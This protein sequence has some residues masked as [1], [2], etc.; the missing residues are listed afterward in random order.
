MS[1]E[2]GESEVSFGFVLFK[3]LEVCKSNKYTAFFFQQKLKE[4][5]L[6]SLASLLEAL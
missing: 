6:Q 3:R 4:E 2:A 5:Y 1:Q